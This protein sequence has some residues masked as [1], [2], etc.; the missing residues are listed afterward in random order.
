MKNDGVKKEW[1]VEKPLYFFRIFAKNY[2]YTYT[3]CNKTNK[4]NT[5][6][7]HNSKI[8]NSCRSGVRSCA[9]ACMRA[10]AHVYSCVVERERRCR[11]NLEMLAGSWFTNCNCSRRKNVRRANVEN[12][13]M[14]TSTKN[15]GNKTTV[16]S[17][18]RTQ[19]EEHLQA[20]P[21]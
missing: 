16:F 1:L 6:H 3:H 11:R 17:F 13:A 2:D 19:K 12:S 20:W 21:C 18:E 15:T 8:N 14:R 9:R 10:R 7:K 4:N 5:A